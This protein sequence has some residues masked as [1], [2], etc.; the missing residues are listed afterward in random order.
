MP[1][2]VPL[3]LASVLACTM[4]FQ[5]AHAADDVALP[6]R[7]TG[8]S[9][10]KECAWPT[11]MLIG[12]TAPNGKDS[13]CTGT[14]VHPQL[15]LYAAHCGRPHTI[16]FGKDHHAKHVLRKEGIEKVGRHPDWKNDSM[17]AIDWGYIKLKEPI[18]NMPTIPVVDGCE[19]S[20]I[21]KVG[22][23]VLF[24]GYSMNNGKTQDAIRLRWATTQVTNIAAGKIRSGGKGITACPGDSGGPMLAKLSD[25]SWRTIG[26]A[27]TI[28]D[29]RGCGKSGVWNSYSQI[30]P[31]MLSWIETHSGVDISPCFDLQGQPTPSEACD[32]YRAYSGDPK[33]PQGTRAKQCVEAKSVR[34]G[35]FC[36]VPKVKE[37]GESSTGEGSSEEDASTSSTT[38]SGSDTSDGSESS[39]DSDSTGIAENLHPRARTPPIR[40]SPARRRKKLAL[41]TLPKRLRARKA[42]PEG[43]HHPRRRG[44]A[45][46]LGGQEA[47]EGS[48]LGSCASLPLFVA[49][50]LNAARAAYGRAR[51]KALL[52]RSTARAGPRALCELETRGFAAM[53]CFV[54]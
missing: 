50:E 6:S 39:A 12:V 13:S 43:T 26:I 53:L 35:D 1:N 22:Q 15:I 21:Q 3:V 19:V 30:R 4:A 37:E 36:E 54:A 24:A 11:V 5:S 7:V 52:I 33:A 16:L 46:S 42:M 14:L 27:S 25:G 29:L 23:P 9:S 40:P 32:A 51:R 20:K 45:P 41:Q 28:S 10:A 31:A 18:Y 48:P 8:G 44:A 2:R 34:A 38:E 47:P 17:T 49:K